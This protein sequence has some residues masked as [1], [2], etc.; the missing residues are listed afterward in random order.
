VVP[1]FVLSGTLFQVFHPALRS[2]PHIAEGST[3]C[4]AAVLISPNT[5][6]TDEVS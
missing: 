2:R 4:A 1:G 6:P 5:S 3:P